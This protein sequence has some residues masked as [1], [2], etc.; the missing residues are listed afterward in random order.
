LVSNFKGQ[1][2]NKVIVSD[3]GTHTFSH[4]K[5]DRTQFIKKVYDAGLFTCSGFFADR[6]DTKYFEEIF[7]LTGYITYD[8]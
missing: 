3:H 5:S 8:R 4:K 6:F 7:A 1:P 2:G